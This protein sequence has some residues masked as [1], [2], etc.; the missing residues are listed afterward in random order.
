MYESPLQLSKILCFEDLANTKGI[1]IKKRVSTGQKELD[2][3]KRE[4]S[5]II[6]KIERFREFS[7]LKI[8]M[9]MGLQT[10]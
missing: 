7:K 1:K 10:C 6:E 2:K 8:P 5:L 9:L 4:F 3:S